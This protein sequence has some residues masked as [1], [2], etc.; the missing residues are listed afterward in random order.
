MIGRLWNGWTAPENADEYERLLKERIF[1]GIEAKGVN[2]YLGIRLLRR[3]IDSGEI[4]FTTIMWFDSWDDV[5]AF[6]GEDFETAYVPE[7]ARKVLARF[8]ARSR[9]FEVRAR[10]D[11]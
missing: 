4:E 6:G 8:D 9:H 11:Y 10:I 3:P 2:G 5:K 1:P 7:S